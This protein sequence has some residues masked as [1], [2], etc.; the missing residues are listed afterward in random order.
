MNKPIKLKNPITIDNKQVGELSYDTNEITAELYALADTKKKIAVGMKN[1]SIS[2]SVEFDFGLHLY[3]GMAAVIA[4][5]PAYTFEDLERV[6]GADIM[7]LSKVG[8]DF[9]LKS[10]TSEENGS[11]SLSETTPKPTTQA[12]ETLNDEE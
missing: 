7:D 9:L 3:V 12:P 2:P 10:D 6:K 4:V 11:E 1:V 8:R 5:N